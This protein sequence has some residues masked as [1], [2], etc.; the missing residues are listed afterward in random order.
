VMLRMASPSVSRQGTGNSGRLLGLVSI[1]VRQRSIIICN[2]LRWGGRRL[3]A[4]GFVVSHPSAM[5]LRK[6]GAPG[7]NTATPAKGK[8]L[9]DRVEMLCSY[10]L[11]LSKLPQWG[12]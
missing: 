7:R 1:S 2:H 3:R 8:E 5:V 4:M 10:V 12:K 11:E 6:D 9:L